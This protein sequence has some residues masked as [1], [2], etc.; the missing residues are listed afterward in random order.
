MALNPVLANSI[1]FFPW[2]LTLRQLKDLADYVGEQ[3]HCVIDYEISHSRTSCYESGHAGF[4][5]I[6]KTALDGK[7]TFPFPPFLHDR[8][9]FIPHEKDPSRIRGIQFQTKQG[10]E[11]SDYKQEI[12]QLWQDI[13]K[14]VDNYFDKNPETDRG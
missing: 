4:L 1:I 2:T 12:V 14:A 10:T 6:E 11:I 5:R 7:V 9:N 13:R 8:F 3:L